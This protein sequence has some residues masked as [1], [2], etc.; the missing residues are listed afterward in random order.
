MHPRAGAAILLSGEQSPASPDGLPLQQLAG[1]GS[2]CS[3]A[4][5]LGPSSSPLKLETLGMEEEVEEELGGCS[6]E[7]A[8]Q[9]TTTYYTTLEPHSGGSSP[10]QLSAS[11]PAP[12][13]LESA[14]ATSELEGGMELSQGICAPSS[15]SS[16]TSSSSMP[17]DGGAGS[18]VKHWSYEEQFKQVNPP[19]ITSSTFCHFFHLAIIG[20]SC[21]YQLLLTLCG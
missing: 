20:W 3:L 13:G 2:D 17:S 7:D 6:S 10:Q 12:A 9:Y 8:S 18:S 14:G 19:P 1:A 4:A 5:S 16:S 21:T 15:S 11:L